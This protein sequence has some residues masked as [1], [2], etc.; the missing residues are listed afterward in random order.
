M[1]FND[2]V[3]RIGLLSSSFPPQIDGVANT[4]CNY[5]KCLEKNH[6]GTLL[7]APKVGKIQP[8]KPESPYVQYASIN[9]VKRYGYPIGI[10]ISPKIVKAINR[11]PV[12]LIHMLDPLMS[13]V[14]GREL[15]NLYDFPN[16]VSYNTKLDMDVRTLVKSQA[17][18]H[19][20]IDT[21]VD[22]VFSAD[23]VWVVSKGA[24][25]NIRKL[26]YEGET[27]F[28]PNGVDMPNGPATAEDVEKVC[29]NIIPSNLPVLLFVG[30][31]IKDKGVFELLQTARIL[32][33]RGLDFRM[34]FIGD[35]RDL[36]LLKAS[37]NELWIEEKCIFLGK[38]HDRKA[39]QTWYTKADLFLF[40]SLYDTNG[41]VVRE[42]AASQ[43]PA[44]LIRNSSAAE[45]ITNNVNGFLADSTPED[46]ALRIESLLKTPDFIKGVGINAAQEIYLSWEDAVEMVYERYAIVMD[47]HRSGKYIRKKIKGD[48]IL[49][50]QAAYMSF[51]AKL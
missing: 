47:N 16:I 43:T 30:R 8:I 5:V 19:F 49:K 25:E 18:E 6:E 35:G 23:E 50:A 22:N 28:M 20:V 27:V 13:A 24:D 26:G 42:A 38:I 46:F 34:V 1:K 44:V 3:G 9:T 2:K 11:Y 41:L 40:P 36:S 4:A 21:V 10:P 51:I 12:S 39:L 37:A 7:F 29:G 33:E 17:V 45:G 48:A 31:I 14:I 15:M 32:K